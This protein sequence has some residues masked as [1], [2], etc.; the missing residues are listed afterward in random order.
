[1]AEFPP[2]A[3]YPVGGNFTIKYYLVQMHYNN[4]SLANSNNQLIDLCDKSEIRSLLLQIVW[5][6]RA[7]DS[8]SLISFDSTISAI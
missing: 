2:V 3:G 6:V 7:C 8:T 5:T 1:M 4:P